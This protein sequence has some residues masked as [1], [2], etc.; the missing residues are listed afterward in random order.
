[1]IKNMVFSLCVAVIL[2]PFLAVPVSMIE[3]PWWGYP[4]AGNLLG[5]I[6]FCG[7]LAYLELKRWRRES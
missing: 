2:I 5:L 3:M 1:M 6:C 4:I 7:P